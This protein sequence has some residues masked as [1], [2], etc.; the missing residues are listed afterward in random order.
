MEVLPNIHLL[1]MLTMTYTLVFRSKALIPIYVYVLL[2]GVY[3]GFSVWWL[4]YLYI[5]TILWGITMLLPKRMPRAVACVVYAAVCTL[6]GL[7]FGVLYAPA[8]ALMW[9]LTFGGAVAWVI[10][11]LPYDLIHGI[12]NV[13]LGLLIVPLA[14]VLEKLSQKFARR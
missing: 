12:S 1:G 9:G 11:G 4:P 14:E 6:H 13:G 3:A 7:C 2:N 8:Q 5:W 10:A